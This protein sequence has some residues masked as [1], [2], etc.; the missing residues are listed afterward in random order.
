MRAV[1]CFVLGPLVDDS[2]GTA[3]ARGPT[4]SRLILIVSSSDTLFECTA[5]TEPYRA[6]TVTVTSAS[7]RLLSTDHAIIVVSRAARR[8]AL[9][10][11]VAPETPI[12]ETGSIAVKSG[13]N[14]SALVNTEERGRPEVEKP[15]PI[16]CGGRRDL[17]HAIL[18]EFLLS[19]ATTAA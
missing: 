14:A 6:V 4:W 17:T 15:S 19:L 3:G 10:V 13:A 12:Y 7:L 11:V 5:T 16:H 18:K 1:D 9:P 2:P 8:P